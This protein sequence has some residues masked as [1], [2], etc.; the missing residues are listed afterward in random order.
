MVNSGTDRTPTS[1]LHILENGPHAP[2]CPHGHGP[3]T[4]APDERAPTGVALS[5]PVCGHRRDTEV[6]ML[7]TLLNPGTARFDA[8]LRTDPAPVEVTTEIAAISDARE[9]LAKT[10]PETTRDTDQFDF[11]DEPPPPPRG[12]RPDGT[13]RT[14]GWLQLG[15]HPIS[16]GL[17]AAL[18]GAAPGL[19]LTDLA[20][21]LPI[22]LPALTCTAWY[23]TTRWL[24]PASTAINRERVR[25]DELLPGDPIRIYGPIGPVGIVE[26]V[27]PGNS[28]RVLVRFTGGTQRLLPADA[29]CHVVH[30]RA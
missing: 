2:Q 6:T 10:A 18:A 3:L 20:P 13:I 22:A 30:L 14:T 19:A 5:C 29:P 11:P 17:W 27:T 25:A 12:Q 23:A 24:R 28:D 1:A 9:P 8:P 15:R 7:R 4:A 21:W 26:Q 16:S